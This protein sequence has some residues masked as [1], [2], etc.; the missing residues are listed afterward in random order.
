MSGKFNL[1]SIKNKPIRA[2]KFNKPL[3]GEDGMFTLGSK[4]FLKATL[5]GEMD[6]H[7]QEL[8]LLGNHAAKLRLSV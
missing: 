3:L 6:A 7:L 1:K 5:E 4:V 2:I 8:L